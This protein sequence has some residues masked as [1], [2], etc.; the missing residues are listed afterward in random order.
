M[1][2]NC[3]TICIP[4]ML[5]EKDD[6]VP[7]KVAPFMWINNENTEMT[8][9]EFPVPQNREDKPKLDGSNKT[10]DSLDDKVDEAKNVIHVEQP[11]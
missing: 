8:W 7:R 11:T 5:A 9:P 4:W 6:W 3:E 2:P 10:K 1:L